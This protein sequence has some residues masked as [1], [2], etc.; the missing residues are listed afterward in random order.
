MRKT[1]ETRECNKISLQQLIW[2]LLKMILNNII[3]RKRYKPDKRQ[4]KI[5]KIQNHV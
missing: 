5:N 4:T 2:K 3:T 1:N